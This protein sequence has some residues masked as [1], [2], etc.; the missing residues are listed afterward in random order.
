MTY[1][2]NNINQHDALYLAA[3][4]YPGSVEALSTRL[5][6]SSHVLYKKLRPAIETHAVTFEEVSE[7]IEHLEASGKED[8]AEMIIDAFCWRHGRTAFK[9]PETPITQD[10]LLGQILGLQRDQGKLFG[11]LKALL[12]GKQEWTEEAAQEIEKNMQVCIS[13]MVALRQ[14]VMGQCKG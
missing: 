5:G 4:A 13:D 12:D 6:M 3:R 2:Y 11:A 10:D 7:I 1:Q 8:K 9:L 14:V